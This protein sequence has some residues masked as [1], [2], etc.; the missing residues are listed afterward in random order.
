MSG[1]PKV[2]DE[3]ATLGPDRED[4]KALLGAAEALGPKYGALVAL[5]L[6]NGL[7]ISE[8]VGAD[9]EDLDIERGHRVLKVT[10]KGGR[11][12]LVALASRT[13]ASL[14]ACIGDRT[15]GPIFV[16][17]LRGRGST[18][19]LSASG[20]VYMVRRAAKRAGIAKHLSPHSLRH[21]FVTLS[22]E[23]GARL[24]DVQDAA[25]HADPPTNNPSV[26]PRAP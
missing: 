13:C 7:R 9:I 19:R 3:S 6:L 24:T 8:A 25:G 18:G 10:R 22:L 17:G 5:L 23:A 16:G 26:R 21:G 14:D 4:G 2:S 20:G 11:T 12:A 1:A 15:T